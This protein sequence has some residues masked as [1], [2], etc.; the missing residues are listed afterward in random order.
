M[1]L[2]QNEKH[3][4]ASFFTAHIRPFYLD[5]GFE[6]TKGSVVTQSASA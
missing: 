3:F 2:P 6:K 4:A 5:T 1:R